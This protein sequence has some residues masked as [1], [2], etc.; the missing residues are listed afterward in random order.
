MLVQYISW[1]HIRSL[2]LWFKSLSL[3][4]NCLFYH[5]KKLFSVWLS[6]NKDWKAVLQRNSC[7]DSRLKTRK[8]FTAFTVNWSPTIE[9]V[10]EKYLS[11]QL[12]SSL[13]SLTSPLQ[14]PLNMSSSSTP[15]SQAVVT[16]AV[17]TARAP[18][19]TVRIDLMRV[20]FLALT[21]LKDLWFYSWVLSQAEL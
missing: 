1:N 14:L 5:R 12:S 15:P 20:S 16:A 13:T 6:L 3:L 8:L 19:L 10:V 2:T 18:L 7:K 21:V 9:G 11:L 4:K 17:R